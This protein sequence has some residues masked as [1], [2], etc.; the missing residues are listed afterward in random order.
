MGLRSHDAVAVVQ[1]AL[2][3]PLSWELPYTAGTALKKRRGGGKI[4]YIGA[5]PNNLA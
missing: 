4:Q 2:I 5:W 3:R 1:A